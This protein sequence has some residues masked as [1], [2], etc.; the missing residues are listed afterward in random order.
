MS[1]RTQDVV[2]DLVSDDDAAPACIQV[3]TARKKFKLEPLL[4]VNDTVKTASDDEVEVVAPPVAAIVPASAAKRASSNEA[5]GDGEIVLLRAKNEQ[6]LPHMRPHCPIYKFD[7]TRPYGHTIPEYIMPTITSNSK[8]CDL[9]YCFACDAPVKDCRNWRSYDITVWNSNHCCASDAVPQ[10]AT[11]RNQVIRDRERREKQER[12]S[13]QVTPAPRRPFQSRQTAASTTTTTPST[14][15][16]LR[17]P[18]STSRQSNQANPY[19]T[20][21]RNLYANSLSRTVT[22]PYERKA[23]QPNTSSQNATRTSTPTLPARFTNPNPSRY[24]N[25]T[26][27][28]T[29]NPPNNP[30]PPPVPLKALP[31]CDNFGAVNPLLSSG[32]YHLREYCAKHRFKESVIAGRKLNMA[33]I[34]NN[35][36]QC[37]TCFCYVCDVQANHCRSWRKPGMRGMMSNHC[38]ATQENVLWMQERAKVSPGKPLKIDQTGPVFASGNGPFS[39]DHEAASQD[40]ALTKCRKCGWYSRFPHQNFQQPASPTGSHDWCHRCGRVAS[41]KDFGKSQSKPYIALPTDFYLGEKS[42][43]F[44]LKAHDPRKFKEFK[45]AWEEEK[46][47]WAYNEV[48]MEEELFRHRFG[49]RPTLTMILASLPIR[50]VIPETGFVRHLPSAGHRNAASETEA[51]LVKE[52]NHKALLRLLFQLGTVGTEKYYGIAARGDIKA[53]FDKETRSGVSETLYS[54]LSPLRLGLT[55][56]VARIC[57]FFY[58]QSRFACIC[59]SLRLIVEKQMKTAVRLMATS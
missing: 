58:R 35:E 51:L 42:I 8:F 18:C 11:R 23:S 59:P 7:P 36:S 9:C 1:K 43:P 52:H 30:T 45:A 28:F 17:N 32:K 34:F 10:F 55:R 40:E 21:V 14:T 3:T 41:E 47:N 5:A 19:A 29:S 44:T 38:C 2:I 13:R 50:E 37:S 24:P 57:A 27:V 22:N 16:T 56:A 54:S 6:K 49:E 4:Q 53:T 46:D 26:A 39:P 33:A 15:T 12:L 31:I 25:S 48:E 20:T